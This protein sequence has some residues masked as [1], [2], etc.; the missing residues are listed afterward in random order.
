MFK[1]LI[2]EDEP[3]IAEFLEDTLLA[4]G[5]EVCGIAG[6]VAEAVELGERHDP[7]LGVVDLCLPGR[8]YGTEIAT[9]LRRRGRFGV[10][11]ATGNPDHPRLRQ[12]EGEGCIIKP[13]LASSVVSALRIVGER[14]SG[15]LLSA[16]P[17]GFRLLGLGVTADAA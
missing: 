14:M 11:Y 3:M 13:Y 8:E 9:V 16:S 4:A 6:T 10:L 12:A 15:H 1:V 7:D 17:R 5:Y 2:V